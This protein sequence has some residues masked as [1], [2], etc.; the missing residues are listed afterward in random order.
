[1]KET[2]ASPGRQDA[3]TGVGHGDEAVEAG[4]LPSRAG[5]Q[6]AELGEHDIALDR[7]GAL[8]GRGRRRPVQARVDPVLLAAP[9][10]RREDLRPDA[11]DSV[12]PGGEALPGLSGPLEAVV[13]ER[14]PA[15]CV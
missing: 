5:G 2:L 8:V 7:V 15:R 14:V 13:G 3:P 1:V 11:L 12:F 4:H 10:P 6:A 9:V